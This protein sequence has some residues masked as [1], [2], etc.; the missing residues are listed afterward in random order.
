[1]CTLLYPLEDEIKQSFCSYL[2]DYTLG[3]FLHSTDVNHIISAI[4]DVVRKTVKLINETSTLCMLTDQ[5][6]IPSAQQDV[7]NP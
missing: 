3:K 6:T 2:T 1:M 4:G 7:E 5:N